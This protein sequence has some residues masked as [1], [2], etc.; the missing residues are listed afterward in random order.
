MAGVMIGIDPHK[1]SHTAVALDADEKKLGQLRVK[2]TPKQLDQ[3]LRWAASWPDRTWAVEGARGLGRLLAQ[4]LLAAGEH[5]VDVQPK[6]A[7]RVR[8]L[9]TGQVN[10]NDPN[11][12]RSV[13]VA[14]LR[15]HTAP[16]VEAEDDTAVLR[17]WSRR[18]RDL[19]SLRTQLVCRLHAVLCDL[20]PGG[21]A[22]E[23]SAAQAIQVLAEITAHGPVATARLEFAHDLVADLQR[24][25]QQRR[26]VKRRL[27]RAVAAS[28]TTLTDLYGV[29]PI[30]AAAVLGYVG[31]IRRFPT[32]DHFAAYNG[33]APIE[34]S[35]GNRHIHRLSRRGNRQLNHAVHMAA[36]TQSATTARSDAPTTTGRSRPA[37]DAK[38][39][40]AHSNAGSATPSTR[41]WSPTHEPPPANRSGTREGNRGTT[42]HPARPA[43][44]PQHQL[45]GKA[46]PGSPPTLRP[47]HRQ[48]T[49]PDQQ[50]P[51][52]APLDTKRPRSA[53]PRPYVD[54]TQ[55]KRSAPVQPVRAESFSRRVIHSQ[56]LALIA[57]SF[58]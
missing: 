1:G 45:F 12:A 5:V 50:R 40:C 35:S 24:L 36:V 52:A 25:D 21:F 56:R 43:H 3:L 18:Y 42:L 28:K 4:Q 20:V 34:A 48:R 55:M 33:T 39:R 14:A 49:S 11:D 38:P 8:R 37:W 19:G 58:R 9:N 53:R 15:T 22:R 27:T 46:T 16:D 6:L 51:P 2:A 23:I 57:Q 7:A 47:A 17:L 44:T 30:I 26:E 10:K 54:G 32:R 29:G 13:A 41:N 31:D